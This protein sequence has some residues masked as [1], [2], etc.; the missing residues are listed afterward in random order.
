[1]TSPLRP[2]TGMSL[3]VTEVPATD[4]SS[5]VTP[6][7]APRASDNR[8]D[9]PEVIIKPRKGWIA[10]NWLELVT[11]R[12]LLF[13]LIWRDVKVKYKQAVLG[14]AWAIF[15]PVIS[16]ILFT[17]VGRAAGF[18]SKIGATVP[19]AIFI[20]AGLLP[21][22]FI[23]AAITNG[24]MSLVNQQNLLSKIYLPRLFM[25][26]SSVGSA[27]IDM[28]LSS[29]V[30]AGMMAIY[31]FL[32]SGNCWA[33]LP[34]LLLSIVCGLGFAYLLSALTIAFR[35]VRFI[36]PFMAQVLMWLSGAMY[37][38]RIFGGHEQWLAINPVYGII[39]GFRSALL[40]E[41]WNPGAILL[42]VIESIVLFFFGLY[43][44]RRAERRF[45]DIA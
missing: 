18:D 34:L 45:A 40:G 31:R 43:Y 10:V 33:V 8:D 5:P 24:G 21:W 39:S 32:P 13:F 26:T 2:I 15:V 4:R 41:P 23:Q 36:I 29:V 42:S 7:A 22:L 6:T 37:P 44:F 1:M 14:F 19:Y 28:A 17:V 35:D 20:Y 11:R 30:F 3:T 27:L 25:P 9:A 38:P 16:V 12:E